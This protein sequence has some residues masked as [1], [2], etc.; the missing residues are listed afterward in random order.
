MNWVIAWVSENISPSFQ[1]KF[2]KPRKMRK[3]GIWLP[4]RVR[5]NK[6]RFGRSIVLN[7]L[8]S[9]QYPMHITVRVSSISQYPNY[10]WGDWRTTGRKC[11]WQ[12]WLSEGSID[13]LIDWLISHGL[14]DSQCLRQW[15][16]SGAHRSFRSWGSAESW[17]WGQLVESRQIWMLNAWTFSHHFCFSS[18]SCHTFLHHLVESL[19]IVRENGWNRFSNLNSHRN[20]LLKW[21]TKSCRN[22]SRMLGKPSPQV[23][24]LR[25]K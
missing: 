8:M 24:A 4:H 18:I 13:W 9:I 25:L 14:I 19:V 11:M 1:K 6:I 22:I 2:Q 7:T 21:Y 12:W 17:W 15:P 23:L 5:R 3:S 16:E 20:T 10:A